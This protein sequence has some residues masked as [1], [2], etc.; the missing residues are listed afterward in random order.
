ME[1]WLSDRDS[2]L[3]QK[4]SL[5][6]VLRLIFRDESRYIY[7]ST[8]ISMW[9]NPIDSHNLENA[10]L[11]YVSNMMGD[12]QHVYMRKCTKQSTKG[13]GWTKQQIQKAWN[14]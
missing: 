12:T 8:S 5:G 1:T 13:M 14:G 7:D 11:R 10:S 9:M 4:K 3:Y 6:W 2:G